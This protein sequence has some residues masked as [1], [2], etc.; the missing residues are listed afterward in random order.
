MR[1]ACYAIVRRAGWT[2]RA[3]PVYTALDANRRRSDTARGGSM[4]LNAYLSLTGQK[5]G[6]IK[7]SV[8]QKGREGKIMVI[9][10]EHEVLAMRDAAS[11]TATGKRQHKPFVITKEIDLSSPRLYTALIGNEILTSWELQFWASS[12]SV[13][14]ATGVEVMRY[15]V[16]LTNASICDIRFCMLNNK[17]PDLAR[18]VEFE[19][20]EF[21]YQ[22][23]EW[24]WVPAALS[25]SDSWLVSRAAP[26]ARSATKTAAR[27]KT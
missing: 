18:Y 9:A 7:G 20:V 27:K 25:A 23:I 2:Q 13:G 4:A 15:S 8:T 6:Q 10:A 5:Q 21:V 12:G 24:T 11:G 3:A 19:E 26:K 14:S 1:G 22:K 16:R 17:N